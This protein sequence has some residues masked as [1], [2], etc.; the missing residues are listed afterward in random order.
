VSRCRWGM[1]ARRREEDGSSC[2]L[3]RAGAK[4]TRKVYRCRSSVAGLCRVEQYGA[5]TR[6]PPLASALAGRDIVTV[7]PPRDLAQAGS[8]CVLTA[9]ASDHLERERRLAA[10]PRS[11]PPLPPRLFSSLGEVALELADRD[12]PCAPLRLDGRNRGHDPPVERRQADAE[13]LRGLLAR[14]RERRDRPGEPAAIRLERAGRPSCMP[15][16]LLASP[17]LP[18]LHGR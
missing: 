17:P 4:S 18:A 11:S 6:W 10:G 5:D 3:D 13:R 15:V 7:K 14:V 12:Q 16:L 9:D 2:S 8:P 1:A